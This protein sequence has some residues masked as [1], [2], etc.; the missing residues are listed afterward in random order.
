M[1]LGHEAE[2]R[3]LLFEVKRLLTH[4][5]FYFLLVVLDGHVIDAAEDVVPALHRD[6]S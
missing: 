6:R 5:Q 1:D 3:H 2:F 4:L